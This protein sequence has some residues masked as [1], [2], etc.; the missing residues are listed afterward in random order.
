MIAIYNQTEKVH[1]III[2]V[3]NFYGYVII[4][5]STHCGAAKNLL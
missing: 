3:V 4:C 5:A 1:E 2:F